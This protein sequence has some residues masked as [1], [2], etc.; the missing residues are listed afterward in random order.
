MVE[1]LSNI[2]KFLPLGNKCTEYT[3]FLFKAVQDNYDTE[4]WQFSYLAFHFIFMWY[5]YTTVWKIKNMDCDRFQTAIMLC[6]D[7]VREAYSDNKPDPFVLHK[8]REAEIIRFFRMFF[9]DGSKEYSDIKKT[10]QFR[11]N[12]A[13]C[14]SEML[15]NCKEVLHQKVATIL[16]VIEKTHAKFKPLLEIPFKTF[17]EDSLSSQEMEYMILQEQVEELFIRKYYL[18]KRDLE[19]VVNSLGGQ[20]SIISEITK[21]I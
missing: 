9:E 5:V 1:N 2:E 15:I 8:V 11:N 14:N 17:C 4:N 12:I 18:S 3:E 21:F 10:V 6:N 7:R 19:Y 13:H 16:D 20:N